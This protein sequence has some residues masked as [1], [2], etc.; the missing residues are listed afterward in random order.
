H[1]DKGLLRSLQVAL[2]QL[3]VGVAVFD[4]QDARRGWGSRF[5]DHGAKI[6]LSA[7]VAQRCSAATPGRKRK[8]GGAIGEWAERFTT[9]SSDRRAVDEPTSP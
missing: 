1:D 6:W 4:Q 2:H 9:R 8:Q 5:F 7:S 3:S